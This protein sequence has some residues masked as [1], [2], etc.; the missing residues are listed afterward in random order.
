MLFTENLEREEQIWKGAT[1]EA[2]KYA[3]NNNGGTIHID[4][5]A[6]CIV[7]KK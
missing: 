1:E 4:N 3:N 7:G 5:E 6:I 2:T